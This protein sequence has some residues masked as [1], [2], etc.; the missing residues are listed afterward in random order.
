MSKP[1][2][3]DC[4]C[5]AGGCTRGYQMAGFEVIGI[6]I[7]RQPHYIGDD[8]IQMDAL[9]AL[10]ILIGGEYITGRT[11]R[12]Y[13][14]SDFAVIHASPPCQGYSNTKHIY[15][16]KPGVIKNIHY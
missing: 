8:F 10:R 16:K 9:E 12:Q 7:N 14:L 2:L 11:G 13:Y 15:S 4:F 1:L 3:L 5:G 6:D